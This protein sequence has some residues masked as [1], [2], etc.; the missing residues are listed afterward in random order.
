MRT[1]LNIALIGIGLMAATS[2]ACGQTGSGELPEGARSRRFTAAIMLSGGENPVCAMGSANDAY[3]VTV[4]VVGK[5]SLTRYIS[6]GGENCTVLPIALPVGTKLS[7]AG[8]LQDTASIPGA[9]TTSIVGS[10]S[11]NCFN[12]E[13]FSV[14][15]AA[16]SASEFDPTDPGNIINTLGYGFLWYDSDN[17]LKPGPYEYTI[18][19]CSGH[20]C[21]TTATYYNTD[22]LPGNASPCTV[23]NPVRVSAKR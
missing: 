22:G 18:A 12:V 10:T 21:P 2:N 23:L 13:G 6:G 19:G 15:L 5:P 16:N 4:S 1:V 7:I 8:V 11:E 3:V 14:G 17:D 9:S 20:G